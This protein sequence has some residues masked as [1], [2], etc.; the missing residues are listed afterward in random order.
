MIERRHRHFAL[1]AYNQRLEQLADLLHLWQDGINRAIRL[2]DDCQRYR[3]I[4]NIHG[5]VLLLT[6]I[7]KMKFAWLHSVYD[8]A[9]T[10]VDGYRNHY[11]G[12]PHTEFRLRG[13]R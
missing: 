5:D 9:I 8:I 2:N 3:M 10:V 13:L 6:V 1:I 7:G 11:L 4:R 12:N